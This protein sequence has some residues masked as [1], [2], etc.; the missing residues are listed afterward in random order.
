MKKNLNKNL[1]VIF[2]IFLISFGIIFR[3]LPHPPNFTPI[4]ALG[5]FSGYF[6]KRKSVWLIPVLAMLISDLFIGFYAPIIMASVY[7]SFGLIALI[8]YLNQKKKTATAVITNS[9]LGSLLF[10]TI[11]NLAVWRFS[12][13]YPINLTGLIDCFYLALPFFRNTIAGDLFFTGL[14]FGA[15]QLVQVYLSTK[16]KTLNCLTK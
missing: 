13:I 5:L 11:T 10:F 8:G 3:F 15:W 7:L 14:F 4:A 9:L 12:G 6:I 1:K 2:Y 16:I